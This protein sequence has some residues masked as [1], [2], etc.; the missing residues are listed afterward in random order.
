MQI[1]A[2]RLLSNGGGQPLDTCRPRPATLI[3]ATTKS[4]RALDSSANWT[5]KGGDIQGI[6]TA[7]AA[8]A[9]TLSDPLGTR[10]SLPVISWL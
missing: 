8:R 5:K 6:R 10:L 4:L 3:Y 2:C 1:P 7:N 9:E